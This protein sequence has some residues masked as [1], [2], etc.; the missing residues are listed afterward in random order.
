MFKTD[1]KSRK[2]SCEKVRKK[3]FNSLDENYE[4]MKDD[5]RFYVIHEVR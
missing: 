1:Q 3:K 2:K 5:I 4:E